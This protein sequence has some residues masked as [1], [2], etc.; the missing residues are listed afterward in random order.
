MPPLWALARRL[1]GK[2][3]TPACILLVTVF[4][5]LGLGLALYQHPLVG[6]VLLVL[7]E[8][9][10]CALGLHQAR[11]Y[12]AP[13]FSSRLASSARLLDYSLFVAYYA[14][15]GMPGAAV[16]AAVASV[17]MNTGV[18]E[19]D[20]TADNIVLVALTLSAVLLEASDAYDGMAAY[21]LRVAALL[22]LLAAT[23]LVAARLIYR[24]A[25]GV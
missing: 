2:V 13:R 11:L 8:S 1:E 16:T 22:P 17:L 18:W 19:S 9:L 3:S 10:C 24:E 6:F 5:S 25:T 21:S 4:G 12:R 20:E 14:S 15:R 7:V 23:G